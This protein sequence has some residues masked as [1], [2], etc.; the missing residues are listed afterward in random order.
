MECFAKSWK[1]LVTDEGSALSESIPKFLLLR[2][3]LL[4]FSC[5]SP[6]RFSRNYPSWPQWFLISSLCLH[7]YQIFSSLACNFPTS[8]D[9]NKN[10]M[11]NIHYE[12]WGVFLLDVCDVSAEAALVPRRVFMYEQ[13][14]TVLAAR[15]TLIIVNSTNR[16]APRCCPS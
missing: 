13:F 3:C 10:K 9:S 2:V 5:I 8:I 1:Y 6:M 7:T 16:R 11:N 15:A 12:S 14:S 4:L